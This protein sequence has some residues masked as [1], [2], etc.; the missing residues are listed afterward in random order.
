MLC[1]EFP[2]E[3]LLTCQT[4]NDLFNRTSQSRVSARVCMREREIECGCV[5]VCVRVVA[6]KCQLVVAA[7]L[8]RR[9]NLC[10]AL[11]HLINLMLVLMDDHCFQVCARLCHTMHMCE[12]VCMCVCVLCPIKY[13]WLNSSAV[14]FVLIFCK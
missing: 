1:G 9:C 2:R 4:V 10:F 7:F 13:L 11:M 12:C 6:H 5:C 8:V 3:V 14:S